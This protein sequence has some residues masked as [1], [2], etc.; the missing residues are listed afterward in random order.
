MTTTNANSTLNPADDLKIY[1]SVIGAFAGSVALIGI[2]L[3]SLVIYL[4]IRIISRTHKKSQHFCILS[5]AVADLILL[6]I[7]G[8]K[9]FLYYIFSLTE[10]VFMCASFYYVSLFSFNSSILSLLLLNF[11]KLISL[12]MPLRYFS[13]VTT[14][15]GQVGIVACWILTGSWCAVLVF[16]IKGDGRRRC[17]FDP[18]GSESTF[19]A[20]LVHISLFDLLPVLLSYVIGVYVFTLARRARKALSTGKMA[21]YRAHRSTSR[22]PI[23]SNSQMANLR[24]AMFVFGTATWTF[25]TSLPYFVGLAITYANM[26]GYSPPPAWLTAIAYGR[27][28]LNCAGNP[29]FTCLIQ[30]QYRGRI[31]RVLRRRHSARRR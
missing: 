6:S 3:N 24:T 15:R 13:M 8:P 31:A 30:P 11:D 7:Q 23:G 5:M 19:R 12:G 16:V 18:F 29:V 25:V 14:R 2:F 20:L 4:A 1:G 28:I 26:K 27:V 17:I 10:P 21:T 22:L 9:I